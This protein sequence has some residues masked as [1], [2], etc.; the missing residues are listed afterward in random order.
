MKL[1]AILT[2]ALLPTSVVAHDGVIHGSDT[3]AAAHRAEAA[4]ASQLPLG[5]VTDLPFNLGGAFE[6]VDQTGTLR[7]EADPDGLPQLLFFGYAN[8]LSICGVAMPMM[9]ELVDALSVDGHKVRPVMVTVD[10]ER[11]TVENMGPALKK[12][13]QEFIG[14]TGSDDQL[15]HVYDLFQVSRE[16]LFEDPEYGAVYAH[17]SHIHLLD[18]QGRVLTLIPPILG[19]ERAGE[20]VAKYLG[21]NGS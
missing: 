19:S 4:I 12:L 6:L 14:L 16:K 7:A 9:A 20:I 3:E 5:E 13:H 17:G 15:A 10:P 2:I 21:N 8:C 18:G 11:D 1:A